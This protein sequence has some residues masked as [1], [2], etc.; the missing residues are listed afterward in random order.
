MRKL[1]MLTFL[2]CAVIVT[3][4]CSDSDLPST[5]AATRDYQT[6]AQILSKF[7]DVNKIIG[8]YYINE[9]KRN[10][11][12]SYISDRDWEELLLVNPLNREIF[13]RELAAVNHSL[14]IAA[15]RPDVAQIVYS[16]YGGKTWVRTIDNKAPVSLRKCTMEETRA[17]TRATWASLQLQHG[18]LNE[19]DFYAGPQIKSLIDINMMGYKMY[20][21]EIACKI[22]AT[23][24]PEG[25]YPSGSGDNEKTIVMSGQGSMES[26]R[27]TWNA[28]STDQQ[29]FWKF[30]GT[31]HAPQGLGD[32]LI[33]IDFTD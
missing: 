1:L 21:F 15:G 29:I 13:E 19:A 4:S 20:Y 16:T 24:T 10:S 7:V 11:P 17:T 27:F 8:E 32:C 6:D 25:G 26:Y 14:Q 28:K 18:A 12:L 30:K 2:L 5:P 33:K 3:S 9:N 23:K 22:E 31:L